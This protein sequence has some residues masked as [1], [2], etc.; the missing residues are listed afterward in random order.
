MIGLG[1]F[2]YMASAGNTYMIKRGKGMITD[3]IVGLVVALLIWLILNIINPDLVNLTIDPLPGLSFDTNGTG[4]AVAGGAD[5]VSSG[6]RCKPIP[7]SELVTIKPEATQGGAEKT[8]KDTAERFYK[9]RE[10]AAKDNIDLKVTDGYRTES[11]Q[12][13][14]WN[15]LGQDTKKVARPCSLGGGGSNH[16]QGHALDIAVGCGNPSS[17][18]S[19]ATYK[20]LKANGG[21]FGFYN[22]LPTDPPHWSATGK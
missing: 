20:W 7:D 12:V 15:Q 22:N 8:T 3:A 11:E 6:D 17:N 16:Q 19:T 10:A 21:K 14:L 2:T 18:C 4:A 9:M 13:S 5:V 1:G